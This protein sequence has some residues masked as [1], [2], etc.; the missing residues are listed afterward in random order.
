MHPHLYRTVLPFPE[1]WYLQTLMFVIPILGLVGVAD[2]LPRFGSALVNKQSRG[3]KWEVAMASTYSNH[4]IVC[5]L[6]KLGCRTVL[7]LVKFGREVVGIELN[8]DGVFGA[9]KE[10]ILT[11]PNNPT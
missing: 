3:Q 10:T 5:G 1:Q 11:I 9:R 7:E 2:G 8:P 6:G 4:V